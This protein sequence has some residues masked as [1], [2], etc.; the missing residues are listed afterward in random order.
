MP[1]LDQRRIRALRDGVSTRGPAL[2]W[3]SRDQRAT[4]N[5][6][7]LYA[8]ELALARQCPLAVAFALAPSFLG[9]KGRHYDFLLAGLQETAHALQERQIPF[10]L[11]RGDPAATI[12][13]FVRDH[14]V[15]AL[16][17]DFDPLRIKRAWQASAISQLSV[18]VY[19]VD[20]HN[21]VPCWLASDKQEISARTLR[22]KIRRLLPEFLTPFPPL[23][24]HPI[25]WPG[26]PEPVDWDAVRAALDVDRT[27]GPAAAFPPGAAAARRALQTFITARLSR[28]ASGRNDPNQEAVSDLSPYLHFGQ[29]SA[30][31]VA[32]A[33]QASDA[34]QE[35]KEAF[36]EEL[37]VRRE[38]ADNYCYYNEQYDT[39]AG[40]P[41]WAQETLRAHQRDPRP[42]VYDCAALEAAQTHD[43]LWNAAQLQMVKTGK[44]HG[45]MRMY[46]AK[47][48]LEWSPT[49]EEALATAIALNDRYELDG[50][51]PNGYT[52]CAWAIGGVHDRAWPSRPIFGKIRYMSEGGARRK[53]DVDAYIRHVAAL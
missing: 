37:I 1:D 25:P 46:W 51:D 33:V 30:Q 9:A 5:W 53:F 11:L 44:M 26:A 31:S 19:Q 6:A 36:L 2:Y 38:L 20:A 3:M 29:L 45:Y 13:A 24:A 17:V 41:T 10:F 42:V 15:S 7:L 4:D 39:L 16:I 49:P 12:P 48:I 35:D 47:K 43:A 21:I 52:G 27:V 28:Y 34:P 22:P 32:L 14:D 50:R 8:R 23:R 18:P 40:F